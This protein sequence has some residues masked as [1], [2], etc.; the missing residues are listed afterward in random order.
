MELMVDCYFDAVFLGVETPDEDSLSLT[1]KFQNT[2][3]GLAESVETITRKGLRVMAGF[4]I[5]FD[6]EQSG[7]GDRIVR[8]VEQTT[9]PTT[10]FAMLQALPNTALWHRLEQ[11]GRL[12]DGKDGN[13]NQTTLM[14]FVPTRPLED[15]AWEYVDAF[16]R[17]YEPKTYLDRIYRHF[18][19]LGAPRAKTPFKLPEL[20]DLKA[21]AIVCW[22]QGIKRNTR[23]VFWHHL[24]GIL[25]HNPRVF[26]HYLAVCAHNEHFLEYRQIVRD[27]IEAQVQ[28]FLAQRSQYQVQLTE[29]VL[30]VA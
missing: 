29:S 12:R 9:I 10:T 2:R 11:E 26:E 8:F 24:F 23:W 30:E 19:M 4:I 25:R 14:N 6:G 27:Q 16:W 15:I 17:I 13:I 28:E 20:V 18:L 22:R 7:A 5:G 1:K 3:S 21:L